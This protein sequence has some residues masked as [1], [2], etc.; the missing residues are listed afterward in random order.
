MSTWNNRD[1]VDMEKIKNLCRHEKSK[2]PEWNFSGSCFTEWDS[3]DS[4][5]LFWRASTIQQS[6]ILNLN[7]HS[8]LMNQKSVMKDLNKMKKAYKKKGLK[9][10]SKIQLCKLV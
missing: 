4:S 7:Q 10:L 9:G 5:D 2:R 6:E 8:K 1:H 3:V